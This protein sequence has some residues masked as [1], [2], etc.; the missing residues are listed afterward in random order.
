MIEHLHTKISKVTCKDKVLLMKEVFVKR[1]QPQKLLTYFKQIDKAANWR[2]DV[3][4][5]DIV[6]HKID[7]KYDS[8]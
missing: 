1:E 6:I 8:D 4:E 2:A 5:K 3:S 7:K